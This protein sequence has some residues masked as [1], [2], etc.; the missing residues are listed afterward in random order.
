[1]NLLGVLGIKVDPSG[2]V[3]GLKVV[4][5]E[6]KKL[7]RQLRAVQQKTAKSFDAIKSSIFSVKGALV[8]A[9]AGLSFGSIIS[10]GRKFGAA[11]G[12]LSAITGAVG[13]DLEYLAAK[14]R[15]YGR[16]T[17]LTAQESAQAFK[18]IA[19]AKPDLLANVKA[20]A[21]VTEQTIILAEATGQDLPTAAATLGASLNQFSQGAESAAQY[22]N[23]LAAGSKFGA[24]SVAEVSEALKFS[25]T[26]ASDAG[27]SF[28]TTV[29]AIEQLSKVAIKGGEAGTGLR[30]VI[31][32]MAATG[33]RDLN[34]AVVG[35]S[36]ALENL[37]KR[38]MS[39]TELMELFGVRSLVAAK[40]L[41]NNVESLRELEQQVTGTN[42]AL[43]Q[44]AARVN[45]L[46]GDIKA[47]GS[48]YADLKIQIEESADAGLREFTQGLTEMLRS[49]VDNW[50][51]V[52]QVTKAIGIMIAT[53]VGVRTLTPIMTALGAVILTL[54]KSL[55]TFRLGLLASQT[56]AVGLMGTLGALRAAFTFLGGPVGIILTAVGAL[57]AWNT[58]TS[59]AQHSAKELSGELSRL[60]EEYEDLGKAQLAAAIVTGT[61]ALRELRDQ[62]ISTN[63]EIMRLSNEL[64]KE[65]KGS[66]AYGEISE[67]L[68]KARG[69][70]ATL[71]DRLAEGR[72]VLED[73]QKRADNFD[74]VGPQI[75]PEQLDENRNRTLKEMAKT[76]NDLEARGMEALKNA[77]P[78]QAEIDRLKR[79][80]D[81]IRAIQKIMSDGPDQMR[82]ELAEAGV[83]TEKLNAAHAR[84][85]VKIAEAQKE[86]NKMSASAKA[87][88]D[89][90]EK[91]DEALSQAAFAAEHEG[92]V[93]ERSKIEYELA[94]GALKKYANTKKGAA[95]IDKAA[96]LD[97]AKLNAQV[98]QQVR[99][100]TA[101]ND[102]AAIAAQNHG[103]V[104]QVQ[105]V[106]YEL[107]EG[108][109][110]DLNDET[111]RAALLAQAARAD[112][113]AL[114]VEAEAVKDSLE[115]LRAY[116]REI[117]R[118]TRL[119][120]AGKL[121]QDEF[122]K[123]TKEAA[124]ANNEAAGAIRTGFGQAIADITS[125][126]KSAAD[127]IKDMAD[128]IYKT[129]NDAVSK[130]L[131]DMLFDSIFN[132]GAAEKD[133][134]AGLKNLF[135]GAG[136][137]KVEDV[138][139]GQMPTAITPA[140][141][142]PVMNVTAGAA[143]GADVG[144]L[145]AMKGPAADPTAQVQQA[146]S[147]AA[148]STVTQ[149]A[150]E[151]AQDEV[152]S[153]FMSVFDKI[154]VGATGLWDRLATAG[155]DLFSSLASSLSSLFSSSG[156]A[157]GGAGG[158]AQL[159]MS[160]FGAAHGADFRVG[161][162]RKFAMGGTMLAAAALPGFA[163][164][165]SFGVGPTRPVVFRA[166]PNET[167]TVTPQ[168]MAG[169]ASGGSFR[170][171]GSGGIDS[172]VVAF[173]AAPT[174][175]VT[176]TRPQDGPSFAHG[177]SFD[178]DTLPRFASGGVYDLGAL[179]MPPQGGAQAPRSNDSGG[180]NAGYEIKVTNNFQIS[181]PNG[182]VDRESQNQ[183]AARVGRSI[184]EAVRRNT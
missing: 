172:Q 182:K 175:R 43:E 96:A 41:L 105:R 21:A 173:N 32:R 117:E 153:G 106:Q 26:V 169:Y 125:G 174:D 109:L 67:R 127:A 124:I 53:L 151:S 13:T 88:K 107:T 18:L 108:A 121:S 59:E 77:F 42:V 97:A 66:A 162:L 57:V 64:S 19:S 166:T 147:E 49:L 70:A 81:E 8:S 104:T 11:I 35:L 101:A 141:P 118:L 140:N 28:E 6:L 100:L 7:P 48:A 163:S 154:K 113:I 102:M 69:E 34:P 143:Q 116:N 145:E 30:N 131:G 139:S 9:F 111:Q 52:K 155:G 146:A 89:A 126:A 91:L 178:V 130:Q 142:L 23:V 73:M 85:G 27:L 36:T 39:T 46:D 82:K 138:T 45:N 20:L 171:G 92:R 87:Y 17:T 51:T 150:A 135:S 71:R 80:Q 56:A 148:Q 157:G 176:I 95:L 78:E 79:A 50:D 75:T 2:A 122:S 54:G 103:N 136:T 84:L 5:T 180:S 90:S 120:A 37:N 40:S 33:D 170:V 62:S 184:N 10:E 1:M 63:E 132:P 60:G 128:S 133:S 177:G 144:I 86:M 68:I 134:V 4:D 114:T 65:E 74:F 149:A 38:Q 112:D 167:V 123:A 58:A 16:T 137:V 183:I 25:G 98:A 94:E 83:T 165:G 179:E 152:Q 93:T 31:L 12:D 47:L 159:A 115:P 161:D 99:E 29:A 22:I 158:F 160:F 24:A 14:S 168:G 55:V 72:K 15:E 76:L 44:Q 119:H 61:E 156:G 129:I 181:A 110:K 3:S 164:G